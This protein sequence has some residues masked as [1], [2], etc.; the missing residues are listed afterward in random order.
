VLNLR[1]GGDMRNRNIKSN[2]FRLLVIGLGV[3]YATAASAGGFALSE[4]ST[5]AT[6]SANAGAAAGGFLGSMYWNSA[7]TAALPGTNTE[8]SYY[9]VMPNADIDAHLGPFSGNSGNI[10][11]DAGT[12]ASYGS[13]QVSKDFWLG[14]GIN[15]P[16]GLATKPENTSYPGAVLGQT[17]KLTMIDANPTFAY[18]IA[19]G[20]TVGAGLQV[21]W[22]QAKLQF[23]EIPGVPSTAQFL[24]TDWAFGGTAGIMLEPMRGTTIGLGYRSQMDLDLGGNFRQPL[25]LGPGL[26]AGSYNGASTLKLP[27]VVTLSLRQEIS[28]YARLLGTAQWTNWSRFKSLDIETNGLPTGGAGVQ[29]NW[30]DGWFFSVGG[31]YDY[32]PALTL[33]G[34]IAYELSPEDSAEKRLTIVPDNNRIWVDVGASYKWND[35]LTFD[36]AYAHLFVQDGAFDS[37]SPSGIPVSGLVNDA[38]VDIVSVGMRTKW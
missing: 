30:S 22:A 12:S 23:Q 13:Y 16:F 14:I 33:R 9:L 38:A 11:I 27:D 15:S 26:P 1:S 24:G 17:T 36:V 29:A 31:E 8:S 25:P 21:A 32:T 7:A 34:G 4:Q 37:I 18:R 35:W 10:G 2:A 3:G 20:V 5:V 19:P 6:G 28:P